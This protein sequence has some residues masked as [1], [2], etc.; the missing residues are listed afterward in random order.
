M[1]NP[2]Q[3]QAPAPTP[4]QSVL[5]RVAEEV[6]ADALAA[7]KADARYAPVVAQLAEDFFSAFPF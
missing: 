4:R 5:L 7:I 2:E 3:P 1:S 6:K